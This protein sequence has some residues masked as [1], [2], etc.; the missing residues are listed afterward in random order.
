MATISLAENSIAPLHFARET[1]IKKL[2]EY[3]LIPVFLTPL[4]KE[5]MVNVLYSE[6]E[7]VMLMG[8]NDYD[9]AFYNE[10]KHERTEPKEPV[11]DRI[12]QYDLRKTLEDKKPY[13]G[14]CRG[15]QALA[16]AAGGT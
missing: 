14:I 13:L 8:G 4:L 12:E 16:I 15:C 2:L 10:V 7:G 6:C 9:P 3:N 1:Y 5:E 11:R